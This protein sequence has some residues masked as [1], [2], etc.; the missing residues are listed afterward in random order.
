MPIDFQTIGISFL[1][2]AYGGASTLDRN[3]YVDHIT[4]NG[5]TF[6][7][8]QGAFLD[9][10]GDAPVVGS[11]ALYSAGTLGWN[12]A[13]LLADPA[14]LPILAANQ[15]TQTDAAHPVSIDLLANAFDPNPCATLA[16]SSLNLTGTQGLVVLNSDGTATYTPGGAFATLAAGQTMTDLF[17][18]TISDGHGSVSTAADTVTVTGV[19]GGTASVSGFSVLSSAAL[20]GNNEGLVATTPILTSVTNLASP[21]N[22]LVD[23]A[24]PSQAGGT[25]IAD[26]NLLVQLQNQSGFDLNPQLVDPLSV[27]GAHDNFTLAAN[28][29]AYALGFQDLSAAQTSLPNHHAISS[30]DLFGH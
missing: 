3:L 29:S 1:N 5:A 21:Q 19:A 2:D 9:S 15:A 30:F 25:S 10:W 7:P 28:F 23:N 11:N 12:A 6:N 4:I 18:Y 20:G 14:A 16:V 26:H 17:H 24:V 22:V 13:A 8:Q 27:N